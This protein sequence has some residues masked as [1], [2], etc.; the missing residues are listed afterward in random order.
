MSVSGS[1]PGH[2]LMHW[3]HA[4]GCTRPP[5]KSVDGSEE[6]GAGIVR[7]SPETSVAGLA[8]K[9]QT[10][11][12]LSY[13]PPPHRERD[14]RRRLRLLDVGQLRLGHELIVEAFVDDDLPL[15]D[16]AVVDVQDDL[17]HP[18]VVKVDAL[19]RVAGKVW[20]EDHV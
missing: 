13:L 17:R 5:K 20:R 15:R 8:T 16:L 7:P 1:S 9:C 12:V 11:D 18:Q 3:N 14:W 10:G 6:V 19:V 4:R 2:P